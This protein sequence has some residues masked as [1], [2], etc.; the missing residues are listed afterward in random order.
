MRTLFIITFFSV[1]LAAAAHSR[2]DEQAAMVPRAYLPIVIR[3]DFS[4]ADT[5]TNIYEAG[6]AYQHDTDNPVRP[7]YNHADKNIELRGYTPNTDA[8]LV[9]ELV[10]YG[11]G[12]STQPP[13]LATLFS[14]YQVPPFADFHQIHHWSWADSPAPGT[15]GDPITGIHY[16]VTAV[17]LTLPSNEPLHVPISGYDIGGG[18][19][20]IVTFADKDTLTLH[21]TREDSSSI[22]Y[23]VHID[24]I[25]TDPNLLALYNTL[26][27][28]SGSRYKYPSLSYELPVLPAGKLFGTTSTGD[29]VISIV[30]TGAFMD[31]RSCD[32]WWQIRPGYAGS[33]PPSLLRQTAVDEE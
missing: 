19:E 17:A 24:N 12:D 27:D 29:M 30:D 8:S 14:P 31:T 16:P 20:V 9:R 10:N 7:A 18:A 32:E 28:E 23:T 2:A 4:C 26:D 22:G 25:C 21:Y 3:A 13:Q 6:T 5:S 1:L 15:R 11:S 33:C